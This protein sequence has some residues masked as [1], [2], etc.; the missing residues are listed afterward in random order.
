[1]ELVEQ[2]HQV[3]LQQEHVELLVMILLQDIFIQQVV[4]KVDSKI[5]VVE[6]LEVL[7]EVVKVDS[8]LLDLLV[9]HQH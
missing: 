4:V 6:K 2:Q 1:M 8:L 3:H 5:I 7:V 9:I